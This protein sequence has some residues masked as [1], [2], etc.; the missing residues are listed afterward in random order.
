MNGPAEDG[1][2]VPKTVGAYW[3]KVAARARNDSLTTIV[4]YAQSAT[5]SIFITIFAAGILYYLNK[6]AETGW[7][8]FQWSVL[9]LCAVFLSF[10]FLYIYNFFKTPFIL[11]SELSNEYGKIKEQLNESTTERQQE[12]AELQEENER[13]QNHDPEKIAIRSELNR[14]LEGFQRIRTAAE[15]RRNSAYGDFFN[16]D[17]PTFQYIQKNV[18]ASRN[19]ARGGN[20]STTYD[21]KPRPTEADFAW[22]IGE[23]DQRIE[24]LTELIEM[25]S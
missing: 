21:H 12:I 6:D 20:V 17:H 1:V 9:L 18:P 7:A 14:S 8:K 3:K 13:L 4:C 24:S 25:H 15:E 11:Q 19:Y 2:N 10:P 23:C 16:L 22:V 5:V